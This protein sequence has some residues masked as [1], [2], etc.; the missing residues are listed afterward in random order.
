M[1]IRYVFV[2]VFLLLI[3]IYSDSCP[4]EFRSFLIG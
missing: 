3:R 4:V 1:D 2:S